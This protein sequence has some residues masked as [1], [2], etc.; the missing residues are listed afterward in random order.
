MN[1]WEIISYSGN[2]LTFSGLIFLILIYLHR[3]LLS[4]AQIILISVVSVLFS[5][6]IPLLYILF[7]IKEKRKI[8]LDY[9]FSERKYRIKPFIVAILSYGIGTACLFSLNAPTLIK[10][11]MLCYFVNSIIIVSITLFW[12]ISVHAAGIT[13]PLTVLIYK[14]GVLYFPLYLIV[15]PVALA[16]IKLKEHTLA[17]VI[18]GALLV[19]FTTWLQI[20][21]I[22]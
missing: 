5:T 12:K 15:V 19:A 8:H 18:G 1:K 4:P 7:F 10:G 21:L 16:R 22:F 6:L 14:L 2:A 9:N 13:G 20:L 11:L 3:T 17:Q